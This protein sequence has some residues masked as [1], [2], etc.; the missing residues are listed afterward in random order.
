MM[1]AEEKL[2]LKSA[3]AEQKVPL[4]Q[5]GES[6]KT[7]EPE[8]ETVTA[9]F[10][11]TTRTMRKKWQTM[12]RPFRTASCTASVTPMR[13]NRR[14]KR[15]RKRTNQKTNKTDVTISAVCVLL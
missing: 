8:F 13:Q 14:R 2:A 6:S 11:Q 10:S 1:T 15:R 9:V 12:S 3:Q 5:R 7:E 4:M